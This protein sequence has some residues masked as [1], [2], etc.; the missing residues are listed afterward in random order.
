MSKHPGFE[1][2]FDEWRTRLEQPFAPR[3][4]STR[5][6]LRLA[7]EKMKKDPAGA[8][9]DIDQLIEQGMDLNVSLDSTGETLAHRLV[10]Q[11]PFLSPMWVE[12][13]VQHGLDMKRP[14]REGL[15]PSMQWALQVQQ[16]VSQQQSSW[17]KFAASTLEEKTFLDP[18][19]T[20]KPKP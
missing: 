9:E 7:L 5:E 4:Q 17:A 19:Q 6:R 1:S 2:W 11:E 16:E 14:N 3:T 8:M 12:H 15:T 20:M 13:L 18:S 10:A